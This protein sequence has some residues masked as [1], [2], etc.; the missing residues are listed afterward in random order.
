MNQSECAAEWVDVYT[1]NLVPDELLDQC[2]DLIDAGH[3]VAT[4]VQ[5]SGIPHYSLLH[6]LSCRY[7][8]EGNPEL[9]RH[10]IEREARS[11]GDHRLVIQ[12]I[13]TI[14]ACPEDDEASLL[15]AVRLLAEGF[16][17]KSAIK[18]V[19]LEKRSRSDSVIRIGF[20]CSWSFSKLFRFS[21]VPL[22]DAIDRARFH[23]SLFCLKNEKSPEVSESVKRK[24]DFVERIQAGNDQQAFDS[25]ASQDL[26]ILFDLNGHLC[27]DNPTVALI[28]KPAR[29]MVNWMNSP[30][31]SGLKAYDYYLTDPFTVPPDNVRLYSE[32]VKYLD[33]DCAATFDLPRRVICRSPVSEGYSFVFNSFNDVFK[34][35]SLTL[36]VWA[37]ILRRAPDAVLVL[38]GNSLSADHSRTKRHIWRFMVDEGGVDPARVIITPPRPFEE[39]LDDYG[40]ADLS[41]GPIRYNGLTTTVNSLWMGVPVLGYIGNKAE[42][43][44][45]GAVMNQVG[46]QDFMAYSL[47]EYIEKA[48]SFALNP[49]GLFDLRLTLRERLLQSAYYNPELFAESFMR[50]CEEMID[51]DR[52]RFGGSVE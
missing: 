37:E 22:V 32:K 38:K 17:S 26:D 8:D 24:F 48:V 30:V 13:R 4:I 18:S 42:D 47:E 29:V 51:S 3:D 28:N 35:N 14:F 27:V 50:A 7:F 36:Q 41:L 33:C 34:I 25:I 21:I 45:A 43:R 20:L 40:T 1:S 49:A 52:G 19:A 5:G 31:S 39:M 16:S 15:E 10:L 9:A 11:S 23:V 12:W 46:L 44:G 2:L 6:A